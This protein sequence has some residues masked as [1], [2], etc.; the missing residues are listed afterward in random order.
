M[1]IR[2]SQ[3]C[4]SI[5]CMLSL[6]ACDGRPLNDPYP[7][8]DL[9]EDIR[10]SAFS[11][12]PKTLDPGQSYSSNEA[13]FTAQIYQ[14]PLQYHYLLRPY[15]LIPQT[16][17]ALPDVTYLDANGEP[18]PVDVAP[19]RIAKTRY[20]LT[21][22]PGFFYAPHPAFA[23]DDA[24]QYR[25]HHLEAATLD[26]ITTPSDFPHLGT[27]ELT[28]ADYVYQIKRLADPKVESPIYSLMAPLIEGFKAFNADVQTIYETLTEPPAHTFLDLR[29][30][31]LSG[32]RVINTYTYEI[33]LNGMYPQFQYW[34]AMPFFAPMPWEADAFYSQKVLLD[35][36][37]SLDW[38]PVGT[39]PYQLV[40]NNPNSKMVMTENPNFS[41]ET[42]PSEGMPE[43]G[44]NGLLEDAGKPLPRIK[45][46]YYTLEKE[47]IPHWSK[48]LQGYYDQSGIS[49][50]TFDQAISIDQTGQPEL[51]PDLKSHDIRLNTETEP[52]IFYL[53]FN[54]H[55][56]VVGGTSDRARALRQAISIAVDYEE[57]ISIFLNG[58][59]DIAMG[60]L[61]PGIF[62]HT[63]APNPIVY[64][65]VD[66]KPVRRSLAEAHALLKQAGYANGIDP[67]T[68]KALV[69]NYDVP[70]TPGPDAQAQFNWMRKQFKKLGIDLNIRATQYNRFQEKMRGG[71]AQLFMW[72]WH[73]DYPDPENFLFLLYGPNSKVRHGGENAANFQNE[74]FDVLFNQMKNLPNSP[75]RQVIIDEMISLAQTQA[76]WIWGFYPK[77]FS[78]SQKWV[79]PFKP[80][81]FGNNNL[82]YLRIDGASRAANIQRWNQPAWYPFLILMVSV[83]VAGI[84]VWRWISYK[85]NRP[86]IR[87]EPP[88]V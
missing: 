53:G 19:E 64:K 74:R 50:D 18:L 27:R 85:N 31:E 21:I 68:G 75:A 29:T 39:G 67:K 60:P 47:S 2:I 71:I 54:M 28:A 55:D 59:G 48:F 20:T 4:L 36:N 3:C 41:G 80:M 30:L 65:E 34:L 66:G 63:Q 15:Q 44:P 52:S 26:D 33:T 84:G 8:L 45:K 43:D 58:R 56:P 24:G 57:Y 22:K 49:A 42:Y 79:G 77:Q 35:K 83:L 81:V 78:L 10:L 87:R 82:K 38:Y 73:A 17:T 6:F 1:R 11:S 88:D 25:Y 37:L 76:P 61:P 46:H 23:K 86:A 72:G 12:P 51:T 16:T 9:S 70:A 7:D 69:L 14:P 5:L 62:G 13:V 40:E 32:A